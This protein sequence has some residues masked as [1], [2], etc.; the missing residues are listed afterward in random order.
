MKVAVLLVCTAI[1][2]DN[3]SVESKLELSRSAKERVNDY[4]DEIYDIL[5]ADKDVSRTAMSKSN[6][7]AGGKDAQITSFPWTVSLQSPIGEPSSTDFHV[8]SGAILSPNFVI[9][10]AHCLYDPTTGRLLRMT[11]WTGKQKLNKKELHES[12]H[13]VVSMAI[14]PKRE[15]MGTYE[16]WDYALLQVD[17]EIEFSQ[18]KQPI[19]L[20]SEDRAAAKF[21]KGTMFTVTSHGPIKEVPE[22]IYPENLQMLIMPYVTDEDCRSSGL[23]TLNPEWGICAGGQKGKNICHKDSGSPLVWKDDLTKE[24]KLVGLASY[25]QIGDCE[26]GEGPHVFAKIPNKERIWYWIERIT[27][28]RIDVVSGCLTEDPTPTYPSDIEKRVP[29]GLSYD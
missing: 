13:R 3:I 7:I 24:T 16:K 15:D 23:R 12:K 2:I 17:P 4:L 10:V 5:A 11:V 27:D 25:D 19:C 21:K 20:V 14:H 8:C 9:T 26:R 6:R 1:F 29:A 28:M 22:Q 18:H